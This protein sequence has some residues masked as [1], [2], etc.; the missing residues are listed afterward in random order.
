MSSVRDP[1]AM[2]KYDALAD[3]L[4]EVPSEEQAVT[5]TFSEVDRI[6]GGL[7]PSAYRIRQWWAND[8]KVEARAWRAAGWHVDAD[9]VDFNG[10]KVRFARGKVGGTRARRLGARMTSRPSQG[11]SPEALR[12]GLRRYLSTGGGR[13]LPVEERLRRYFEDGYTGAA[14]ETYGASRFD[15][16]AITGDDLVAA[17]MLSIQ[18]RRTTTSGISCDAATKLDVALDLVGDLLRLIPVDRPLHTLSSEEFEQSL[19][20]GSPSDRLYSVL[21]GAGVPRVARHK[22]MARKRPHL[23]PVRDTVVEGALGLATSDLWWRPWWEALSGNASLVEELAAVPKPAAAQHL[24]VLR[25]ADIAVWGAEK[26][27]V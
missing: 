22:L 14:F 27:P 18:I 1:L 19:G 3:Y 15:P 11:G 24:G 9:G 2:G 17:T 7:P 23:F 20:P 13:W 5:L 10:Q 26:M 4:R 25:T 6:V 16:Y 12:A 8:S 21:T